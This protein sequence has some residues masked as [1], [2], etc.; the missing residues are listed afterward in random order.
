MSWNSKE[1]ANE[2]LKFAISELRDA[3]EKYK[4][5]PF[6]WKNTLS[7]VLFIKDRLLEHGFTWQAARI[8]NWIHR[9][10]KKRPS[11]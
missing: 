6:H 4:S 1:W 8:E 3:Y 2:Q 5:N 7:E 10:E 11:P 9:Y